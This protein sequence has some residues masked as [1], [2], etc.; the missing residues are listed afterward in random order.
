M[1]TQPNAYNRTTP[2]SW[3]IEIQL[4]FPPNGGYDPYA[5]N[6][7]LRE[8]QLVQVQVGLDMP[9]PEMTSQGCISR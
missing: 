6:N 2:K 7:L 3:K 5:Q 8:F 9:I 1:G 4:K